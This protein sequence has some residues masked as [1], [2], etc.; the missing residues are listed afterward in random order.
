MPQAV[1]RLR[2]AVVV[3]AI[4]AAAFW[5]PD[6]TVQTRRDAR[7]ADKK[8]PLKPGQIDIEKSRVY[9]R[10]GKKKLGH[11]HGVEGKI[12][13]G[14]IDL[15]AKKNLGEIV[16]DMTSFLADTDEAREH[17]DL[18]GS[19]DESTREK[20]TETMLGPAVL[21]VE[22]FPT[23]KLKIKSREVRKNGDEGEAVV[24][25]GDFTL[26]G[27]TRPLTFEV[28]VEPGDGQRSIRGEFKILQTDFGI[29][30]YKAALGAVGVADELRIWGDI[31]VAG[32]EPPKTNK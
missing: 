18:E 12:K 11:E 14:S 23:A 1:V 19:I 22:Q 32:E 2:S 28:R 6:A 30:P 26:H 15:V 17:V 31:R 25:S 7:A 27:K 3:V 20:V 24:L 21:D 4:A 29:T 8:P 5:L 9:V 16:F 13:S 10:V